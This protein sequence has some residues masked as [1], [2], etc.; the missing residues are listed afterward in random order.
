MKLNEF[1]DSLFHYQVGFALDPLL[2]AFELVYLL[3]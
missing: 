3:L 1:A 2:L